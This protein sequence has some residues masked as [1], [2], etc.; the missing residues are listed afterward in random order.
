M[1]LPALNRRARLNAIFFHTQVTAVLS[2]DWMRRIPSI[3]SL[4]ATPRQYDR[5]GA[6]YQHTTGPAC[7]ENWKWRLNRNCFRIARHIVAWSE[8][9]RDGLMDEYEVPI[10]KITVIPPGVDIQ[11]WA[12]PPYRKERQS[13][14]IRILFV[15]ANLERKGGRV[16]LEA[17][18]RLRTQYVDLELHLVTRDPITPEPAVFLYQTMQPNSLPL[19]ELFFSSDI[20][21]LPT[22]G[23]CLPLVLSEAG[24][25]GLPLISTR[26]AAIPEI[27]R[28]GETGF[29]VPP[30]DLEA[31]VAAL[32]RLIVDQDL[33][34]RQGQAA[35]RLV[36]Q[37]FDVGRN[38][39]QLLDLMKQISTRSRAEKAGQ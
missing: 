22:Q 29:V 10:D 17:F 38:V 20:F 7:L 19:K 37:K 25:A 30:G 4:D 12:R 18:R 9:A 3:V 33:R 13:S 24:A 35:E 36:R 31:L 34:T 6:F 32:Q 27:V 8:W 26:L 21:C 11:A 1:I 2:P 28:D 16:L 15:G 23:D 39:A 14:P 5:L